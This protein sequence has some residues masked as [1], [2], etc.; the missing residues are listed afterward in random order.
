MVHPGVEPR[1][2]KAEERKSD[3][4]EIRMMAMLE[5]LDSAVPDVR[6]ILGLSGV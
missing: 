4:A 1:Q 2:G 6:I 5:P 3:R